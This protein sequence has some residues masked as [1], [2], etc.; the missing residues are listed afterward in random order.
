MVFTTLEFLFLFF[1]W[2]LIGY[3]FINPK[4]G[5]ENLWLF[6]ASLG[7]YYIGAKEN[8]W[9]LI[10]VILIAYVG[11]FLESRLVVQLQ[12][13]VVLS[14]TVILM[15]AV[16]LYFKYFNFLISNINVFFN[17]NLEN[18]EISLPIGISFFIFQALSYVVDVYRGEEA[19]T[20]PIDM[21]LYISFFP[22]LI[23]G[24]IVRFHDIREYFRGG[25]TE[26][27]IIIKFRMEFGAF[28]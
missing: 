27:L 23:A 13:K 2:V 6:F 19:L 21:G 1:P 18:K 9:L 8:F 26:N 12:K 28:Q 7:F 15:L 14:L 24:P 16:M 10:A 20:N 5:L 4:K 25:G 11:G 17:K 22:Q 3:L